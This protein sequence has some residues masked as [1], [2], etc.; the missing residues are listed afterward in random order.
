[1]KTIHLLSHMPLLLKLLFAMGHN[2]LSQPPMTLF[3]ND[4]IDGLRAM[5]MITPKEV[6]RKIGNCLLKVHKAAR[7]LGSGFKSTEA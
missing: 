5:I 4:I 1:M 3:R 7:I 6:S 2:G